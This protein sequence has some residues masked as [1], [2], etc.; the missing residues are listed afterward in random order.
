MQQ[1]GLAHVGLIQPGRLQRRR[2][3]RRQTVVKATGQRA[4]ICVAGFVRML[5]GLVPRHQLQ[6]PQLEFRRTV[7]DDFQRI[8]R[9]PPPRRLGG[10]E[11]NL[12]ELLDRRR[13]E[14]RKQ[15]AHGLADAGRCLGHQATASAHRLVHRLGKR[16][17]A[18]TKRGMGEFQAAQRLVQHLSVRQ[19]LPRPAEEYR[20][21]LLEKP[22]QGRSAERLT[23]QGFL[24][25][26]NVEIHQRQ[27]HFFKLQTLAEQPAVHL[28]L[29][30]MQLTV[31]GGHGVQLAAIGFHFFQLVAACAVAV[32]PAP[33]RQLMVIAAQRQLGLIIGATTRRDCAMPGNPFLRRW[34]WRETQIE[35][36]RLG[37]E[38]AQSAHCHCITCRRIADHCWRWIGMNGGNW[39][40]CAGGPLVVDT[41]RAYS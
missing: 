32:C 16:S 13:L 23:N 24:L 8:Q 21:L 1:G 6:H 27:R 11:E 37:R 34:R 19:L 36:T 33:H 22:S 31:V 25:A 15:R 14:Q 29:R 18:G 9:Q 4:G 17:L 3:C 26:D 41:G 28:H 5:A 38:L 10:Q 39:G 7:P 40:H 2:A 30:P 12:V 20:A 35:I